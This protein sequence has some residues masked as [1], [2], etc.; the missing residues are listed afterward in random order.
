MPKRKNGK[1]RLPDSPNDDNDARK[2][3]LADTYTVTSRKSTEARVTWWVSRARFRKMAPFP[4]TAEKLQLAAAILKRG[5]YRSASQYLYSIKQEHC[6][7]GHE[8]PQHWSKLLSDLRRSC[9]RGLGG[10]RQAAPLSLR[11]SGQLGAYISELVDR[12]EAAIHVGCGWLLREIELASLKGS[13]VRFETG[14]GC[15]TAVVTLGA[16]K[17]DTEAVGA[18]R[19]MHCI[20][21]GQACPV[22]AAKVLAAGKGPGE[23]LVLKT[24]KTQASKD[25]VITVLKEYGAHLGDAAQRITGHSMRVTGA[26]RMAGAG[27][28]PEVIKA[29]G[30]WGSSQQMAKYAREALAN[31]G[32]IASAMQVA[33][34]S[35]RNSGASSSNVKQV[36]MNHKWT[37]LRARS[38]SG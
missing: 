4:L 24:D 9:A 11:A 34:Q 10:T 26:Q 38:A 37:H 36:T 6:N 2:R 21:P 20:C 3:L 14:V 35:A 23:F 17:T 8:W 25:N 32:V 31:P 19:A 22:K 7:R 12:A 18:A 30:R 16:T 13:D 15:G 28:Q 29:F 1:Q 33:G 5:R 27:I